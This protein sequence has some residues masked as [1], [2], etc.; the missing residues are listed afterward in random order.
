MKKPIFAAGM[1]LAF[2]TLAAQGQVVTSS[3]QN[4]SLIKTDAVT[5]LF[6]AQVSVAAGMPSPVALHFSIKQGLHINSH[7]PPLE[8]LIPTAF[9]IP[10][11]MGVR[12]N[13]ATYPPGVAFTLPADPKTKLSVYTGEFVI[14]ARITAQA[15]NRMVQAKLRYQACDNNACMPPRTIDVPVNVIAK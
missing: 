8:E 12:L 15:G 10:D 13:A 4:R 7:T 5:Y 6:P 3:A 14:Q 2:G 1:V 11:G 9:S